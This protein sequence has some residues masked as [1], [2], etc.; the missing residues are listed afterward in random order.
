MKHLKLLY[1]SGAYTAST[2]LLVETNIEIAKSYCEKYLKLGYSV[3][4][5]HTNYADMEYR[6]ISYETM[7]QADLELVR[8]SDVIVMLPR[9]KQS[10]GALREH[11]L[12]KQMKKQII[13][14][15]G[16]IP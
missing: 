14:E 16:E 9:W 1:I 12:A 15:N 8:R 3:I 5:P 10:H 6:G 2:R 13:Y 4:C 7:L 11:N